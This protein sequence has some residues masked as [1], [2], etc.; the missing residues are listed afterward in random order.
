MKRVI[1][2]SG[3]KVSSKFRNAE[4]LCMSLD[5]AISQGHDWQ[6]SVSLVIENGMA[7]TMARGEAPFTEARIVVRDGRIA[8]IGRIT[9][10]PLPSKG[11]FEK[12]DATDAIILPGLINAHTHAAM[13]LFRGLADDLPLKQ[14]LFE[15]IFPAE[16]AFLNADT[17]YWG[18]LLGCLEMI[19][20]GTTCFVDGYFFQDQT[21]RAVHSAGLRG[22]IAQGVID[23]PAPG[24]PDPQDNL[25]SARDFIEKWIGFS[26]LITPGIFCHS[27]LTCSARTLRDAW[28]ISKGHGLPLQIHLSETAEEVSET[29]T[30]Y[31]KRPVHYLDQL[32]LLGKSLIA[33]HGVHLNAREIERLAGTGVKVVHVPES[34]MKLGSGVAPIAAMIRAGVTVGVGTDGCA[35]NNDMDIFCEMETAAKAAKVFDRDPLSLDAGTALGLATTGGAAVMGLEGEIGTLEKGKKADMIIVELGAP[36]LCPMYDPVSI[37]VYSANGSDVRDVIVNGRILMR[38]RQFTTVDADEVM[39][40]VREIGKRIGRLRD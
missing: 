28:E 15:K 21:V 16:A 22:L 5:D 18:A 3:P 17:V 31:G 14:W 8:D 26:D 13:T 4:S 23:F 9:D 29:I 27:P 6:G 36:H 38:K 11:S 39:G 32:G 25:R 19:A 40:K 34:N 2:L 7:V 20:S 33:A 37:L 10:V 24:I 1:S 35:S 12:I 30:R